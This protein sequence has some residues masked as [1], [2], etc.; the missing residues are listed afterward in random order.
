MSH[1][2]GEIRTVRA[3]NYSFNKALNDLI[4][5]VIYKCSQINI[6]V[7]LN[8]DNELNRLSIHDNYIN[9]FENIN[10]VNEKNPF[11]FA[12]MRSG[13]NDDQE[14]SEFGKG[15]KY[16][17]MFLGETLTVYTKIKNNIDF[18]YLKIMFDFRDMIKT[19]KAIDSYEPT[20]AGEIS[21][22]EY[23]KFHV[24]KNNSVLECVNSNDKSLNQINN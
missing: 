23:N 7:D 9:G 8:E 21:K 1:I 22:Q 10:E 17:S 18:Q 14:T 13:H 11:N 5:N 2:E 4:D 16:A 6:S 15:M 19:L 24:G 20:Y 12:H 3:S